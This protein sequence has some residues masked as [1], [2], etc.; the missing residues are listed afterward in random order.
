MHWLMAELSILHLGVFS[1]TA[2]EGIISAACVCINGDGD[3]CACVCVCMWGGV[4]GDAEVSV[5]IA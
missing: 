5:L 3:V 1:S 4:G 2:R